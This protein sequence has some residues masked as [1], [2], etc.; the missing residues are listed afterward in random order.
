M[1]AICQIQLLAIVSPFIFLN[2]NPYC[3]DLFSFLPVGGNAK[4]NVSFIILIDIELQISEGK[5]L[6][7]V[8]A[9]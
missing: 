6:T 5:S 8:T 3:L 4:F 7:L 9:L 2:D 1:A